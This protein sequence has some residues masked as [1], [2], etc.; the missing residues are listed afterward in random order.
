MDEL[1]SLGT[2][3]TSKTPKLTFKKSLVLLSAG[4]KT[5]KKRRLSYNQPIS[6]D[7]LEAIAYG[8]EEG[9]EP[10]QGRPRFQLLRGL[11][12]NDQKAARAW[13]GGS[14]RR[15][16]VVL[17]QWGPE[18]AGLAPGLLSWPVVRVT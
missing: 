4:G 12:Q 18:A 9:K 7:D 5:L 3:E 1:M 15:V 6:D 2:S 8:V 16:A 10:T 11:S 13:S 17:L 14:Q